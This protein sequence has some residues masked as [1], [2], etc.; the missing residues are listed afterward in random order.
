MWGC[1]V[2]RRGGS[3]IPDELLKGAWR[4]L[5]HDYAVSLDEI[6]AFLILACNRINNLK[7]C[8]YFEIW[9]LKTWLSLSGFGWEMR[10]APAYPP[11]YQQV[12]S[13]QADTC[14]SNIP[15]RGDG[16]NISGFHG[17]GTRTPTGRTNMSPRQRRNKL[18]TAV[19]LQLQSPCLNGT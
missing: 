16:S 13:A 11:H 1:Q 5:L 17:G 7:Y 14:L 6:L 9:N 8:T 15:F 19:C 10:S 4:P 3:N 12:P 18:V 2:I